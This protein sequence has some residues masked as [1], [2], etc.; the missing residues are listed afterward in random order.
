[1]NMKYY[2]TLHLRPQVK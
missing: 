2:P 1:M